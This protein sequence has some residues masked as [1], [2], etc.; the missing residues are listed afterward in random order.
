MCLYPSIKGHLV[1]TWCGD[2]LPNFGTGA[3]FFGG[4]GVQCGMVKVVYFTSRLYRAELLVRTPL[5]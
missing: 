1:Y 5:G 3:V 4:L 2:P